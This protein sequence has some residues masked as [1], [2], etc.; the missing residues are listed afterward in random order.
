[1][2]AEDPD[3][4]W[5]RHNLAIVYEAKG[6]W[7]VGERAIRDCIAVDGRVSAAQGGSP[8][9]VFREE[10]DDILRYPPPH[11]IAHPQVK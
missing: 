4:A 11:A 8:K 5:A 3:N 10:L 9:R 2:L 6:D 7:V 1:M